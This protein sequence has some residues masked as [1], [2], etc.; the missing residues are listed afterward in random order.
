MEGGRREKKE[1]KKKGET[2][3]NTLNLGFE[4]WACIS[5]YSGFFHL[6]KHQP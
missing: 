3:I 4:V 1:G 2:S 5:K 6:T